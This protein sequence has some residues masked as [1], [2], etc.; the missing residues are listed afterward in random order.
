MVLSSPTILP[1]S[2]NF[3]SNHPSFHYGRRGSATCC[4]SLLICVHTLDVL[5]L[6]GS[7][8]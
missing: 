2:R 4:G 5:D 7:S 1:D 6:F 3:F 8:R